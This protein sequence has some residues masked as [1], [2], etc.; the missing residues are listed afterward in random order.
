MRFVQP[1][2]LL[3]GSAIYVGFILFIIQQ[4]D[5]SSQVDSSSDDGSFDLWI[6]VCVGIWNLLMLAATVIA[7]VDSIRAVRAKQTRQLGVDAMVAKLVAIPFFLLNFAFLS[8]LF[9]AGLVTAWMGIGFV[10]WIVVAIAAGMTYLTMLSTSV[11]VWATIAQLRKQRIIG[12]G[13]TV[14]YA[15]LSLLFVTDIAAGVLLFA[16]SRRRP[17]LGAVWLFIGTGIALVALGILDYFSKF[18]YTVFPVVGILDKYYGVPWLE[19][20]IPTGLGLV[21]IL[22]TG[23]IALTRRSSLH[24]EAQAA[25]AP[26][27]HTQ[28]EPSDPVLVG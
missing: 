27:S 2:V 25:R 16:H 5:S 12:T 19:W 24:R 20:A 8:F 4:T 26:I 7:I 9:Q 17:R 23:V 14:L 15:I 10:A 21:V 11:Y 22:V 13:L 18:L 1:A 28:N 6:L 3:L